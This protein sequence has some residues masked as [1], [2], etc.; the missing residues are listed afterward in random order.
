[1][2]IRRKPLIPNHI[3]FVCD[4]NGR[5]AQSR[6][7]N[8]VEGHRAGADNFHNLADLL[9]KYKIKLA[10]VWTMS[11]ENWG[12]P[13]YE[14]EG[15]LRILQNALDRD[16]RELSEKGV[17]IVHIGS[18]ARLS[19]IIRKKIN[20]VVKETQDNSTLIL[21]IAFDYGGKQDIVQAI[22]KMINDGVD[23]QDVS[24]D[25]LSRY[26]YTSDLP[27]IDFLVRSGGDRRMSNYLIWQTI[28]KPYFVTPTFWPDFGEKELCE[29]L[30]FYTRVVNQNGRGE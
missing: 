29:S 22:R 30:D 3:A 6:G 10:T 18:E 24:G 27:P 5:W 1:M 9:I 23:E 26:L 28:G 13:D 7:L 14:I 16:S 8:R 12:R 15:I 4:G 19:R 17:R 25:L 21:N 11:N 2:E 20:R